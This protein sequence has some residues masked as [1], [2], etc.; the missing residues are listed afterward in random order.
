[1]CHHWGST[2]GGAKG[3]TSSFEKAEFI[4]VAGNR[5]RPADAR[6]AMGIDWMTRSE[7]SQAIP[8][9]YTEFIGKH[10]LRALGQIEA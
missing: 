2:G 8:P 5:F 9:A 6:I 10:L 1:M 7:L 4:C 3:P